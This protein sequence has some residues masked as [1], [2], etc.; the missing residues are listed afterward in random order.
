[1]SR[2]LRY[3]TEDFRRRRN[4]IDQ[5]IA[6]RLPDV[7][8][9]EHVK[10]FK[11]SFR[12]QGFT[13]QSLDKW[14]PRKTPRGKRARERSQGRAI[15]IGLANKKGNHMR[16]SFIKSISNK[17][18]VIRNTKT[19]A[20]VHNEGLKAGRG[21]GFVMPKRQFAGHSHTLDIKMDRMIE[22]TI[23]KIMK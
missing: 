9:I 20:N 13:D 1:M 10:H 23:N 2:N 21:K 7:V 3:W 19:Y 17:R 4:D 5:Y 12:N 6:Q 18:V 14:Q 11:Q 22:R 15:L 8:G 16:D